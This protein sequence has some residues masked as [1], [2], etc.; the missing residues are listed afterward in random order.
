VNAAYIVD[1]V[2][3]AMTAPATA[4]AK[5]DNTEWGRGETTPL[6]PFLPSE[7]DECDGLLPTATPTPAAASAPASA[8]APA[9]EATSALPVS[10]PEP[11]TVTESGVAVPAPEPVVVSA[12]PH[13]LVPEWKRHLL[14]SLE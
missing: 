13:V 8:P 4:I 11:L 7:G 12:V 14:N 1:G 2:D 5:G 9:A 10:E 6:L 3:I